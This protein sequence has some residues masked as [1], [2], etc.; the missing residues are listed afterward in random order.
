MASIPYRQVLGS[1]RYLVTCTRP[2]LC[3]ITGLLSRF[4]Q[5]PGAQH[6]QALKH[7]LRYLKHT[8]DI[9]RHLLQHPL[10]WAGLI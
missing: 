8:S 2:D 5:N 9:C 3:F 6:W 7:V 10:L 4:M 1:L